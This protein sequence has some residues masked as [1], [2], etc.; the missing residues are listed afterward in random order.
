ME[1]DFA[2]AL[3]ATAKLLSMFGVLRRRS[4]D[5][6]RRSK[7]QTEQEVGANLP[8]LITDFVYCVS[9]SKITWYV[10]SFKL[11]LHLT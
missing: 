1:L 6:R 8:L 5:R 2:R 10:R 4:H 9:P 3:D 11:F 7:P